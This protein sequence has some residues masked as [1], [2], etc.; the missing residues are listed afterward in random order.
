MHIFSA[1]QASFCNI[2]HVR[3]IVLKY[4]DKILVTFLAD[5]YYFSFLKLSP[6]LTIFE[7]HEKIRHGLRES[8]M[9]CAQ[10]VSFRRMQKTFCLTFSKW[11]SKRSLQRNSA[12]FRSECCR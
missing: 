10:K 11:D 2:C 12:K 8:I 5:Y 6:F 3:A 7:G 1:T 4:A 9:V